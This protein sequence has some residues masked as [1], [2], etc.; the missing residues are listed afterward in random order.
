MHPVWLDSV[1]WSANH[2]TDIVGVVVRAVKIGV[3]ADEYR[4]AHFNLVNIE[5][6][7]LAEL[8]R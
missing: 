5:Q 4:H 3:V 6:A 2:D 1:V 7:G 8:I